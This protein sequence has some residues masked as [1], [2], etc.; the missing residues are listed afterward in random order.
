MA[1]NLTA[2]RRGPTN[3]YTGSMRKG[4][5]ASEPYDIG[6]SATAAA[7]DTVTFKTAMKRPK[8]VIGP[9][10]YTISGQ[11]VTLTAMFAQET[12]QVLGVEVLGLP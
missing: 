5:W 7:G 9:Y 1:A 8:M 12:T 11:E 2:A 10:Q 3:G 6:A 4:P